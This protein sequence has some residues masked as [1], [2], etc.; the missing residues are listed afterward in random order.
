M[1]F[2]PFAA[3]VGIAC[4][5]AAQDVRAQP[6]PELTRT[7]A[8]ARALADDPGIDAAEAGQDAAEAGVRQASRRLNPTLDILSENVGGSGR[9]RSFDRS[10]TTY[11]FSQPLEL[12]GDRAARRSVAERDRDAAR[13]TADIRRLDLIKDVEIAYVDAQAAQEALALAEERLAVARELATAVE[14]RVA[15]A[16][17]PLMA[18]ARAQARLAE[19][20]VDA[21]AARRR[22][23]T[24]RAQLASYWGGEGDFTLDLT[25]FERVEDASEPDQ[26]SPDLALADIEAKR[27]DARI[28]LER[29]RS[30][31]DPQIQGGWRQFRETDE[32]AFVVG[33]TVPLQFWDRNSGAI[34]RARSERVK[35]GYDY[36]ARRRALLRERRMLEAQALTWRSEVEALDARVIP[37]SEE[38]L[39]RA[40]DGYAQGGFSYLDVL[41][42]QR[43]LGES[44]LRR[45]SA[46]RSFHHAHS[47][48]ARLSGAHA[49]ASFAEEMF[50]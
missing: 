42:A 50:P 14:R 39:K 4:V 9:F 29:A 34:A 32:T 11:S 23:I 6:S 49:D 38:A 28:L 24:A 27:A 33:F 25:S 31:P 22:A 40:R 36:D 35:A 44:R 8:L 7:Q 18:G 45:I 37:R 47:A 21:D 1:S 26:S 30:I 3:L 17:D 5:V 43:A 2:H 19:A 16:R 46:L 15:A 48:L 10:E 41:D 13:I 20:E 12:G